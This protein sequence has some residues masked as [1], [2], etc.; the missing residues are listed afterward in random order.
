MKKFQDLLLGLCFLLAFH[1]AAH[2]SD[3]KLV[4]MDQVKN[5]YKNFYSYPVMSRLGLAYGA[6]FISAATIDEDFTRYYQKNIKNSTTDALTKMSVNFGEWKYLIPVAIAANYF[7]ESKES[8]L[9]RW[10]DRTFRSLILGGPGVVFMQQVTG[11]SRP[12]DLAPHGSKWKPFNDDNGVSGHAFVGAVP[13]LV[14]ANMQ[15]EGSFARYA[16][17]AASFLT[18]VARVNSDSHY[19]SQSALGWYMAYES[20]RAVEASSS[21]VQIKSTVMPFSDGVNVGLIYSRP[22]N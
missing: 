2:A 7:G 20:V 6:G 13:F 18:P 9:G 19:L 12:S 11:A 15:S 8:G 4:D 17:I 22:F 3:F 10:G 21:G 16:A 1:P 5:D 14:Y